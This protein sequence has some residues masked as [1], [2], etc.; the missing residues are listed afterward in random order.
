MTGGGSRGGWSASELERATGSPTLEDN[1][2]TLQYNGAEAFEI[3]RS[4][5]ARARRF[6]YLENYCVRGDATGLSFRTAL[7]EKAREGVAVFV[8]HDWLGGWATPKRFWR[9]LVEA[10]ARVH[11]FNPPRFGVGNPVGVLQRD[12]RKLVVV[13]GDVG[14]V[15]GFCIGDEWSKGKRGGLPWR[16]TGVE[17][18]G[19][20]VGAAQR[21]FESLWEVATGE[22]IQS[23]GRELPSGGDAGLASPAGNAST[24]ASG[25]RGS[26]P[27]PAWLVGGEPG[28]ARVYRTLH[29]AAL[30]AKEHIWITDAY[31]VAPRSI[32]EALAAAAMQGVD[33][34]I[35]VPANNNWPIVRSLSRGGY[36]PLLEAGARIFE[37]EGSMIHAKT[38]VADG[39]WGRVGS[40]NLNS[41]SLLANWE[42]DVSFLDE[43]LAEELKEIFLADLANAV[44]IVLPRRRGAGRERSL[45]PPD[46]LRDRIGQLAK[47][48]PRKTRTTLASA[49][50]AGTALGGALSGNRTLGRED[51]TVLGS[52]SAFILVLA[53][54]AAIFPSYA[55][56]A[57]A[58]VAGW[59]GLTNAVRTFAESRKARLEI[60]SGRPGDPPQSGR[61][62]DDGTSQGAA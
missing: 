1:R 44:E 24:D 30:R 26:E 32:S 3:W 4:A 25:P 27:A 51:R 41:A 7:E 21:A 10:G 54:L 9:P 23:G 18:K 45:E 12:H 37:W 52:V 38:S 48:G 58:T 50:R 14:F 33:V 36:R 15:G 20:L 5:I 61:G 11:R 62:P 60:V 40:S 55:G 28:K 57:F 13:D 16:D 31:F 17:M 2:I 8:L 19:P 46:T 59:F 47:E 6:V 22:R 43:R 29:M 35:L 53:V 34:R 56:W 42:L 39:I 49:V